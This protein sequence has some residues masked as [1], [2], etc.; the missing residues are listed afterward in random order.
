MEL[1]GM[2]D[3]WVRNANDINDTRWEYTYHGRDIDQAREMLFNRIGELSIEERTFN[4]SDDYIKE[5]YDNAEPGIIE[6]IKNYDS[7][8]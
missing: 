3:H 6:K 7:S 8:H 1:K 2:K 5:M 4:F